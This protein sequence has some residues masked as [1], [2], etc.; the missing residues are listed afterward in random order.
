[1]ERLSTGTVLQRKQAEEKDPVAYNMIKQQ[2]LN[3]TTTMTMG[4]REETQRAFQRVVEI[5]PRAM[6]VL[7]PIRNVQNISIGFKEV[8]HSDTGIIALRVYVDKKRREITGDQRIP[9]SIGGIPTDVNEMPPVRLLSGEPEIVTAGEDLYSGVRPGTLGCFA[10]RKNNDELVILSAHH[11][12][13]ANLRNEGDLV[14]LNPNACFCSDCCVTSVVGRVDVGFRNRYIDAALA[15]IDNSNGE[16]LF[17]NTIKGLGV[18]LPDGTYSNDDAPLNGIGPVIPYSSPEIGSI[19][20][21]VT[22]GEHVRKVGAKTGR[23]IGTVFEIY[24]SCWLHKYGSKT[25]KISFWEQISI[26]AV[27]GV[28]QFARGGDSGSIV[29]N[30][31]NQVVG[32]LM[33]SSE[34]ADADADGRAF[35]NCIHHVLSYLKINIYNPPKPVITNMNSGTA[36][37]AALSAGTSTADQGTIVKYQWKFPNDAFYDGP[38]AQHTFPGAGEYEVTLTITDSHGQSSRTMTKLQIAANGIQSISSA[39]NVTKMVEK[40]ETAGRLTADPKF[41]PMLML[42]REFKEEVLQLVNK[43]RKVAV[44]WQR[45][46]GPSFMAHCLKSFRDPD[47]IIPKTING[48]DVQSLLQQMSVVLE[49]EGSVP[50]A[51]AIRKYRLQVFNAFHQHSRMEDIFAAIEINVS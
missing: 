45:R 27:P 46:N 10:N 50:L 41:E 30:D 43:N 49:E 3:N 34:T 2:Q 14:S 32:L 31:N 22:L 7:K 33:A 29:V 19:E 12:L 16:Y 26:K 24:P 47:H 23:T 35:M 1:M 13:M 4:S 37:T 38:T 9:A 44:A 48:V 6:E 21:S 18:K 36:F 8:N 28:P 25:E 51:M 42:F 11:V 20:T 40:V 17:S 39:V 15:T 5:L